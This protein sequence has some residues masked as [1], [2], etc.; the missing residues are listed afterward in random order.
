MSMLKIPAEPAFRKMSIKG[1]AEKYMDHYGRAPTS[2]SSLE[3]WWP[4]LDLR[5]RLNVVKLVVAPKW[6]NKVKYEFI[7]M[8]IECAEKNL[9]FWDHDLFR[10]LVKKTRACWKHPL[11]EDH[12][13]LSKMRD[14]VWQHAR[15]THPQ[16]WSME[17]PKEVHD[18]MRAANV[19]EDAS[20]A[21]YSSFDYRLDHATSHCVASALY[22]AKW[23]PG[24][25]M[26]GV[27][28]KL[29]HLVGFGSGSR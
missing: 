18:K 10:A 17:A 26:D 19:I 23:N 21:V 14:E 15:D 20:S 11:E 22:S 13:V 3:D 29:D 28:R 5:D 6:T 8:A 24:F 1:D 2:K 12:T 9:V 25:D 7:E 27:M 16:G 4:I